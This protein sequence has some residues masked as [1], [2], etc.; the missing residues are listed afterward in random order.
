[1][2]P[3]TTKFEPK[4][5]IDWQAE[6]AYVTGLGLVLVT[7]GCGAVTVNPLDKLPDNPPAAVGFWTVTW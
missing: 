4:I 5:V 3:P 6:I 7:V 2:V 1:M